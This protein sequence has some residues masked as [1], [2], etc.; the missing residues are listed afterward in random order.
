MFLLTAESPTA[1]QIAS[2]VTEEMASHTNEF[3]IFWNSHLPDM[4]SFGIKL[5]I[6]LVIFLIGRILIRWIRRLARRTFERS[7]TDKGV[8]QFIDSL[9]KFFLYALLLFIIVQNLGV[10][11]SSIAA[12]IASG[13]VAVSLALQGSLSNLAGGVQ[14]LLLKP[15]VVGDYIREDTNGNE[16][17]VQ[18]IHIFYT[19]LSTLDNRTIII[20]NGT[21]ANNSLTNGTANEN[22][23]LELKV[24]ISYNSDLKKA[25]SLLEDL[26]ASDPQIL[27]D[28]PYVVFVDDLADSAVRLGL[29]AK[30][31]T[32]EYW[33]TRWR[34]LENIKL[35]FDANGIEIPYTQMDVHLK[36]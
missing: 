31:P 28:Q 4:I 14:L 5:L 16:G 36:S 25:K 17:T 6:S 32:A 10:S 19:K 26:L 29:R 27:T 34:L 21:L 8:E 12:L 30:V 11:S 13:G 1:Q 20:P 35:T 15:F 22:R 24:G 9:L 23:L 33:P 2:E 18:E 7:N 3:L